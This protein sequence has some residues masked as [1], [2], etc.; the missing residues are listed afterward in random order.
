MPDGVKNAKAKKGNYKM[1]TV[2]IE[3]LIG[4]VGSIRDA[5]QTYADTMLEEG[6]DIKMEK[7]GSDA[8]YTYNGKTVYRDN[9][10]RISSYSNKDYLTA[11]GIAIKGVDTRVALD[12]IKAK[13]SEELRITL[14]T[15]VVDIHKR[16]KDRSGEHEEFV[17]SNVVMATSPAHACDKVEVPVLPTSAWGKEKYILRVKKVSKS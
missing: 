6:G 12:K 16:I 11:L 15:Y 17:S 13:E 5:L 10:N 14:D 1:K 7:C 3:E 2:D 4:N 8:V 9:Y